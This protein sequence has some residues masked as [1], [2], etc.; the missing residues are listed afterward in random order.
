MSIEVIYQGLTIAK[1]PGF[2]L[3]DGGVFIELDGPM[4]VATQLS[5]THGDNA[6]HGRVRRVTEGAGAGM[7]IVPTAGQKLPRW[8]MP[9]GPT[10]VTNVE[11]EP[12]PPPAAV[13][14]PVA[15]PPVAAEAAAESPAPAIRV[16][17]PSP[18]AQSANAESPTPAIRVG[19]PSPVAQSANAATPAHEP[20]AAAEIPAAAEAGASSEAGEVA[21]ASG[22]TPSEPGDSAKD[23]DED[24]KH[25][26]KPTD[27]KAPAGATA[28]K[29]KKPRK[30]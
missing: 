7:L 3:Q 22:H 4:P 27:K 23:D 20:V 13:E 2:R 5:L 21:A 30:R 29:K 16:G 15:T 14:P 10:S 25:A 6:L 1:G 28:A 19:E 11:L 18:V 24:D 12:E 9:L 8:L 17:E 26:A